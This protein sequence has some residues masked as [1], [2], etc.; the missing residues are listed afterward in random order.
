MRAPRHGGQL[1][2]LVPQRGSHEHLGGGALLGCPARQKCG[3]DGQNRASLARARGA[4]QQRENRLLWRL[5]VAHCANGPQ[6]RGV[7]VGLERLPQRRG[8]RVGAGGLER[9]RRG[10]EG[11]DLG[12]VQGERRGAEGGSRRRVRGAKRVRWADSRAVPPA[13]RRRPSAHNDPLQRPVERLERQQRLALPHARHDVAERHQVEALAH[14]H[15]ALLHPAANV[16]L[17]ARARRPPWRSVVHA[18]QHIHEVAAVPAGLRPER[19]EL[20]VVVRVPPLRHGQ[21]GAL[22]AGVLQEQQVSTCNFGD[23]GVGGG[24]R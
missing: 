2:G 19:A 15:E 5:S 1:R 4:L 8:Q 23:V 22:P 11:R 14:R 6:L 21:H 12:A 16:A 7:V 9:R 17:A 24:R 10:R 3:D 18:Y 20:D 13:A